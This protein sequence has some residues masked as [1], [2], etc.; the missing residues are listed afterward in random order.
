M[1]GW[2]KLQKH[3][4]IFSDVVGVREKKIFVRQRGIAKKFTITTGFN[5][6]PLA[7]SSWSC[8]CD[9]RAMSDKR[10]QVQTSM[11]AAQGY[12]ISN[13][14]LLKIKRRGSRKKFDLIML[15]EEHQV[16]VTDTAGSYSCAKALQ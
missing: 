1:D 8:T 4:G 5:P 3:G 14:S 7:L 9:E 12:F 15:P 10:S 6:L 11:T 2:L 13:G 16:F